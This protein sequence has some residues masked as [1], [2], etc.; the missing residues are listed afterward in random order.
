MNFLADD[1]GNFRSDIDLQAHARDSG[2]V[3]T[4]AT[5]QEVADLCSEMT[6]LRITGCREVT[7][8]GLW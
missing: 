8:V 6:S 3:V 2:S 7:D 5:V 4:D 1:V